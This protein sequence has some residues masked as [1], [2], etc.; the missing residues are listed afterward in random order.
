MGCFG[1]ALSLIRNR[2][3]GHAPRHYRLHSTL[4]YHRMTEMVHV[5]TLRFSAGSKIGNI[6][7]ESNLLH[8]KTACVLQRYLVRLNVTFGASG[9]AWA[10][11]E[12]K[13]RSRNSLLRPRRCVCVC[14]WGMGMRLRPFTSLAHGQNQVL[15]ICCFWYPNRFQKM[16]CWER[17]P[18][19]SQEEPKGLQEGTPLLEREFNRT[20]HEVPRSLVRRG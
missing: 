9:H 10:G 12:G 4:V 5:G 1:K 18:N 6:C 19:S 7:Q 14:V 15:Q 11:S 8:P 3:G 13:L 2:P 20:D 16:F 17:M